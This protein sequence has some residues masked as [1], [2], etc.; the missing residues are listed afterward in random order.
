MNAQAQVSGRVRG[1]PA[2]RP[3]LDPGSVR[4]AATHRKSLVTCDYDLGGSHRLA[5]D[6][7]TM[8]TECARSGRGQDRN[9]HELQLG[10]S[11]QAGGQTAV[12]LVGAGLLIAWLRLNVSG[13]GPVL[14]RGWHGQP[15]DP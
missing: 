15:F 1:E 12:F 8:C 3:G 4:P 9:P 11:F 6:D 13:F 5:L 14:A 10:R 7:D 2:C